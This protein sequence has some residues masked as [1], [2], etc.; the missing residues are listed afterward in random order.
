MFSLRQRTRV[1]NPSVAAP[2]TGTTRSRARPVTARAA[3]RAPMCA[4]S[5][6]GT[7]RTWGG[8][9]PRRN[10]FCTRVPSPARR[11]SLC[12]WQVSRR[13]R[14]R[15]LAKMIGLPF[16]LGPARGHLVGQDKIRL[17]PRGP[18]AHMWRNFAKGGASYMCSYVSVTHTIDQDRLFACWNERAVA[19]VLG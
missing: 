16:G 7:R 8:D 19:C 17:W 6:P 12:C 5:G 14:F 9:V 18:C 15:W 13:V 2:S 4:R 11:Q 3:L 10:L 1:G